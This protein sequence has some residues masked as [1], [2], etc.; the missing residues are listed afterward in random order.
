MK[1]YK[2]SQVKVYLKDYKKP[3]DSLLLEKLKSKYRIPKQAQIEN[4]SIE[5]KSLD[6]RN[7]EKIAYV[8]TL[9]FNLVVREKNKKPKD[10][11]LKI[12]SKLG[13]SIAK[14]EN[15]TYKVEKIDTKSIKN[16]KR[17]IV[18]GFG[19]AGIFASLILSE[20]GLR[21]IIFE[22]G[23]EVEKRG[24]D[25]AR[26]W[27]GKE[28]LDPN[29]NV[30]FGEG[31]A[32][33]FSDGKLTT[34]IKDYRIRK[35][36]SEFVKMGADESIMY[37]QKPHIGTD[38]LRVIVRNLRERIKSLGGEIYFAHKLEDI[39]LENIKSEDKNKIEDQKVIKAI[40]VRDLEND[41]IFKMETNS[42]VLA[43]GHSARDTFEMLLENQ[44]PLEQKAFSMGVRIEHPQSLI[45]EAQYGNKNIERY[46]DILPPADYKLNHRCKNG[47]GVY[48]FCMCPG[49]EVIKA[50]SEKGLAVTNGMSYSKRD[51]GVAN[52]GL[53]VDVRKEDF[54]SKHPLAG[55]EFQRKY[56]KLAFE[57]GRGYR[58]PTLEISEF[59][60][61]KSNF[62]RCDKDDF[63]G[64]LPPFVTASLKEALPELGKKLKGFDFG[65]AL[66]TAVESRSSSPVRLPRNKELE[67]SIRG[68]YPAGEGLGHAGGI[69]SA[70]CDGIKVAEAIIAKIKNI[71][72]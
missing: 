40:N 66:L 47:R 60:D 31:G 35:V 43:I 65:E 36:F 12:D 27:S 15:K 49:G 37:L 25:V 44:F 67:C 54:L 45:D 55:V 28:D 9:K 68:V 48:T 26:F 24:L 72:F 39:E 17:P 71:E 61:S 7:K 33:T 70:A 58:G 1:T 23:K 19:P 21:P 11:S 62:D 41:N 4:L 16:F 57:K 3:L 18:I 52:S 53:L 46:R 30:Q 13:L 38:V 51:S 64:A 29:S 63:E 32:G 14:E 5:K 8:Y 20:A 22:R 69:T 2:I 10:V 42:L 56:E 34:G 6:C 50:A 59:L